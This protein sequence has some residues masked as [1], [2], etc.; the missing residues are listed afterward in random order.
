[1][2]GGSGTRLWPVSR[3]HT[4]KQ[5]LKLVDNK[6]LL[7]NTFSRLSRGFKNHQVFVA[8]TKQHFS[9]VSRQLPQVPKANYSLEPVLK[10]RG[11]AIGLAALLMLQKDKDACFVTAWADHYI[12][13]EKAYFATLKTAEQFLRRH[14]DYFLTIGVKPS[15]PHTGLGYIQQGKKFA[16]GVHHATSFKEKPDQKTAEKFF[17]SGRYLWNTGYFVCRADTLI[18]L[19]QKHQPQI[20]DLLMK[21]K[22]YIGTKR[23]QWA[24]DKFY[25]Q[26]PH[27][28]IEKGLVEKLDKVAVVPASFTWAD[29]GSWKIVKDV[30][31]KQHEN[32]TRGNVAHHNT[33]R[34]LVYN[35]EHKLVAVVGA[36][37]LVVINTKDALLIAPKSKS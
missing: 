17:R 34:S 20:Y 32:L 15:Y 27:V 21:I 18:A 16:G 4:P 3:K 13:D 28:D 11:P 22:P 23:Q 1:M 6:T 31:S 2:A 26:M 33:T 37:D 12:N 36:D 10:D 14:P 7:E 19:Y 29:I 30:L 25:P 5:L 9:A 8:T 35:Y 24:I